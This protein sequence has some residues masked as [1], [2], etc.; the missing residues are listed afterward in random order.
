M[1]GQ[2]MV[3]F[4]SHEGGTLVTSMAVENTIHCPI[5][6]DVDK[7]RVFHIVSP[8]VHLG[9]SNSEAPADMPLDHRRLHR[10]W[11]HGTHGGRLELN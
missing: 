11:E 5:V 3:Q 8:P 7:V 4:I 10:L 1:H 2:V 6:L 9:H